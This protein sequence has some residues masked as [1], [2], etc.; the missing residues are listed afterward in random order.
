MGKLSMVVAL[1]V[2][3]SA[4]HAGI[5][6]GDSGQQPT[7]IASNAL[8]SAVAQASIGADLPTGD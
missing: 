6:V 5:G 7:A 8:G 1:L 4:C 3:L 2:A